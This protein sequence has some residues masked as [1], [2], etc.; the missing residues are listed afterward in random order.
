MSEAIVLVGLSGSGKSSVGR[1]IAS[2]LGRPFLDLDDAITRRTGRTPARLIESEGEAAF[3]AL[4]AA[5]VD[6]A[7]RVPDVVIATGGGAVIDPLSRWALWGA[8][9]TVWL[10]GPDDRLVARVSRH[11]ETRPLLTGD[12][13]ARLAR[14][15]TER[16]PFY[17]AADVRV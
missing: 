5:E 13:A 1:Q 4:E 16:E 15:R 3:R 2:R 11:A 8:G 12:P 14:Q 10:D 7:V 17:A 9:V 6:A